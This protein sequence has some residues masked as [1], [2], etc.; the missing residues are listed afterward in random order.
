MSPATLLSRCRTEKEDGM[1][2]VEFIGVVIALL[3]PV[4]YIITA[5]STVQA[6]QFAADA[7]AYEAA[8]AYS[9]SR[10]ESQGKAHAHAIAQQ[11]FADQGFTSGPTI[12]ARCA[13]G[14]CP[15]PGAVV[16]V[17]VT[18]KVKLPVIS[19]VVPLSVTVNA[20]SSSQVGTYVYRE[21]S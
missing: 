2:V 20:E 18:H 11:I 1:A 4:I 15:S 19:S 8:R 5:V 17:S 3:I 10:N 16:H 6:A 7:S 14:A 21:G 13:S 9:L 12:N